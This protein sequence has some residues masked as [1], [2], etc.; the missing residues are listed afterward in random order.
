VHTLDIATSD[1]ADATG[2]YERN[3]GFKVLRTAGSN[4]ASIIIGECE[5]RL[6]SGADAAEL[7]A[8]QGEGLAVICLK[9]EMSTRSR[10]RSMRQS[11][12]T[13]RFVARAISACS[14]SIRM[15]PTWFRCSYSIAARAER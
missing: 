4:D 12:H 7:I 5:I 13:R 14:R 8:T 1:L 6:R 10:R 9:A 11:S 3:F 2:I 15:R